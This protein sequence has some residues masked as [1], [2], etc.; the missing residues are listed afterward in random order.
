M[1]GIYLGRLWPFDKNFTEIVPREPLRWG[2]HARGPRGVG[3][4]S[5]F[6]PVE[7]YIFGFEE[8][9]C[10]LYFIQRVRCRR[11]YETSRSGFS[12]ADE[13]LVI[14]YR[15]HAVATN[16]VT[17]LQVYCVSLLM[18]ARVTILLLKNFMTTTTTTTMTMMI[19]MPTMMIESAVRNCKCSNVSCTLPHFASLMVINS[20]L[21]LSI[22]C[23]TAVK[24]HWLTNS[25]VRSLH[26]TFA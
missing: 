22:S 26:L 18:L 17:L 1:F 3:K 4:Y 8:W 19:T 7:G 13:F 16:S 25:I 12:S 10:C 14:L 11:K 21:S 2:L 6:G 15:C 23:C 24:L 20:V 9:S 5:N